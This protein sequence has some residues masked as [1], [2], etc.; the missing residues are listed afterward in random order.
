[1]RLAHCRVLLLAVLGAAATL[2]DAEADWLVLV[3]GKRIETEG[4][5][6]LKGDLLTVH[7]TSG[8][9]LAVGTNTVDAMACLKLNHGVL[10]IETIPLATP[11]GAPVTRPQ[12]R[13]GAGATSAI[14]APVPPA[15]AT[16]ATAAPARPAGA[17]ASAAAAGQP[18]AAPGGGGKRSPAAASGKPAAGAAD[19]AGSAAPSANG[20]PPPAVDAA[21]A[22]AD[23]E[24]AAKEARQAQLQRE[25]RYK[26]IVDGCA[27][28][29]VVDRAGFKRCVDSQTQEAPPSTTP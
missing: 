22:Q 17:A 6:T 5:W 10:H 13:P 26:K 16:A 28:M 24:K 20:Q 7:E 23:R 11:V 8:R 15:A 3:G 29:F 25:L 9:I 14:P 19:A 21:K 27:R 4:P 18:A 2:P 12:M 1:M